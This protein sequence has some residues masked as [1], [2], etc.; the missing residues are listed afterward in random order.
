MS[1][2]VVL[3]LTHPADVHADAVQ[4]RLDGSGVEVCRIDTAGL[5]SPAAPVSA[6]LAGAERY[7]W[8][9]AGTDPRSEATG[10]AVVPVAGQA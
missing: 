4:A 10:A 6:H 8:P 1:S 2:P 3:I 5:G 9:Q 7:P